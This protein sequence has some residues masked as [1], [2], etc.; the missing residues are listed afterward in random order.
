MTVIPN[1]RLKPDFPEDIMSD[2]KSFGCNI[3]SYKVPKRSSDILEY[4]RNPQGKIVDGRVVKMIPD[5]QEFYKDPASIYNPRDLQ[6]AISKYYERVKGAK[7]HEDELTRM[8]MSD[9]Y[10]AFKPKKDLTPV[11]NNFNDI[12]KV[13]QP[14]SSSGYPLYSPRI[15]TMDYYYD[16]YLSVYN[17]KKQFNP[18]TVAKRT[19]RN[20]EPDTSKVR[21]VH[22]M[23]TD[24]TI[25]EG[26]FARP[27]IDYYLNYQ[28]HPI[29]F[30]LTKTQL[31]SSIINIQ[32]RHF[33]YSLDYSK[34][35]GSIHA[36][37]IYK[38]F[39]MI[40][41]WMDITDEKDLRLFN[42][43]VKYFI[44]TPLISTW[45]LIIPPRGGIPSGS[46]FTQIIG[47]MVNYFLISYLIRLNGLTPFKELIY[48]L[49]DDCLLG[50]NYKL[51]HFSNLEKLFGVTI[52]EDK[53]E[54]TTHGQQ[55]HF[56]GRYYNT[57][58]AHGDP[59]E[60]VTKAVYPEGIRKI[61]TWNEVRLLIA[62]Y[63]LEHA[64]NAPWVF[65]SLNIKPGDPFSFRHFYHTYNESY[66]EDLNKILEMG[67]RQV[68]L[69]KK[70][71]RDL[72]TFINVSLLV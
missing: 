69:A 60:S 31:G 64:E 66:T 12:V 17:G 63:L 23:S 67:S 55:V 70:E 65:K 38:M 26:R 51:K 33:R 4:L 52:H 11:P 47:S 42:K 53:T 56:L 6:L 32:N 8:A 72:P 18:S 1:T 49:G 14:D 28:V 37:L 19:Q 5:E 34:F 2:L 59:K 43:I 50:I 30:G 40:K 35:D 62:S 45:G 58:L 16:R 20:G 10:K 61:E 44:Q 68:M 54:L 29:A 48:V 22:A 21:L 36:D 57:G 41:K 24:V 39:G 71:G 46:Y 3:R 9:V 27:L 25:A 13:L 15:D 7:F